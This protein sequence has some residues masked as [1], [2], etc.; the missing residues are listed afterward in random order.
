LT[1]IEKRKSKD[2]Q[3]DND[4][5]LIIKHTFHIINHTSMSPDRKYKFRILKNLNMYVDLNNKTEYF[6]Y[7][8][9]IL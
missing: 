8:V 7:I 2:T 5:L 6:I 4:I 3:S 9:T 1:L